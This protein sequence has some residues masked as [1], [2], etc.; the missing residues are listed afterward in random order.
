MATLPDDV[1]RFLS[2]CAPPP[3]SAAVA[4]QLPSALASVPSFDEHATAA[5]EHGMEPL[6]LAHVERT[7]LAVPA[8][9]RD[10]LRARR[11]QHAHAASVRA[12][13]V[14]DVA[15]AMAQA[16]VPFLV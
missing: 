6:V 10:R 13:V 2:L 4:Q 7:D 15:G 5:E 3:G 11:M 16:G 1:F 14:A 9:F 12:R 8:A